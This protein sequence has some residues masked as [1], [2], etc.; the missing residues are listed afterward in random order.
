[1]VTLCCPGANPE[2][3]NGVIQLGSVRPSS[4]MVAPSGVELMVNWPGITAATVGIGGFCFGLVLYLGV[5]GIT[6][7]SPGISSCATVAALSA[8]L[9]TALDDTAGAVGW[10]AGSVAPKCEELLSEFCK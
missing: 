4:R 3:L 9:V 10:A 8:W 2:R 1:M 7:V 6:D 5:T